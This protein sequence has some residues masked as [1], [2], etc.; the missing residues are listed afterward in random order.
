MEKSERLSEAIQFLSRYW[1][2]KS[3]LDKKI[4]LLNV[5]VK[6]KLIS[7]YQ[8]GE[9]FQETF[10]LLS[11]DSKD[12]LTFLE[13]EEKEEL[14]KLS[15]GNQFLVNV[16]WQVGEKMDLNFHASLPKDPSKITSERKEFF[17][18]LIVKDTN[19]EITVN[20]PDLDAEGIDDQSVK[21]LE[22]MVAL[23]QTL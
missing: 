16:E 22:D 17:I 20:Y 4:S 10:D 11:K 1:M 12:Y 5:A 7:S 15:G 18:Q 23:Y 6:H 13:E 3:G 2:D 9:R 21:I 19:G 8:E 14:I